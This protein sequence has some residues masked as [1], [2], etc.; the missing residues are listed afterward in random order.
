MAAIFTVVQN[1]FQAAP[2]Q[3]SPSAVRSMA[4]ALM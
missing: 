2:D 3:I 4:K 1:E